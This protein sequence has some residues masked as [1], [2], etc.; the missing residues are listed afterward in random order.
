MPATPFKVISWSPDE[1]IDDYKL[2]AMNSNDNWLRQ[3]MVRGQYRA[4]GVY[5]DE[6]IR[7]ASGLALITARKAST[8]AVNVNFG[9]YFSDGC[10]PVVTTG[11]VSRAQRQIFVTVDGPGSQWLP[12]RD[13]FQVHVAVI[14]AKKANKKISR[15][16]YVAW[17]AVGY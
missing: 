7:L 9:Q 4:N 13:G 16:F 17:H 1:P 6:G 14:A 2:D 15:N 3:V 10:K 5:R 8:A 11:I 12:S